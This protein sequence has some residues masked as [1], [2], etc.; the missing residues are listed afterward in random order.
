MITAAQL[1]AARGLL[2]WTR[3]ELADAAKISPETV[4]NI[5]HG[6]FR[7]QEQTAEAIVRAFAAHDVRFTENEGVQISKETV[8]TFVGKQGYGQ[9]LDDIASTMQNGGKTRQFNFSDNIIS[10]YAGDHIDAYVK[11]MQE[12]TNLDAQCLVPE[13]DMNF[14]VKHCVYKW[15]KKVHQDSIPYFLYGNK[16]AMLASGSNEEM[17]WV[18]IYSETLAKAFL[19]QFEIYW[20]QAE[21]IHPK[22][23]MAKL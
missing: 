5:E 17:V 7:P 1:R 11:K 19:S 4:K 13:G 3:G 2:D 9:F 22:N 12:I 6:T 18:S 21:L 10:N 14:P 16:I 23:K 8:R 15:L 20:E